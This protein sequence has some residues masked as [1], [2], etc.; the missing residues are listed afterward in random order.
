MRAVYAGQSRGR[1][2]AGVLAVPERP[3]VFPPTAI[4]TAGQTH[5]L[6]HLSPGYV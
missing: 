1:G 3:G 5:G 6:I 2:A 4:F